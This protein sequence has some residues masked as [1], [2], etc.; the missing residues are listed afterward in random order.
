MDDPPLQE[1]RN[2]AFTIDGIA[3]TRSSNTVTDALPGTTLTLK[4]QGGAAEDLVVQTDLAAT[5]A[6]LQT[7]VDAYNGVLKLVQGEL[8]TTAQTDRG[9][10]LNGDS[11]LRYLQGRLQGL[12]A[13]DAFDDGNPLTE[14]KQLVKRLA[15]LGLKSSSKDGSLSID[16]A[17]LGAAMARD[18][19]AV[20]E[21]FARATTGIT[22]AASSLVQDFTR[23]GDGVLT[24]RKGSLDAAVKRMDDDVVRLQARL[25]KY[26]EG[27]VKRFAA[28]EDAISK[29]KS[30]GTFLTSQWNA[31]SKKE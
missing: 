21:L 12:V 2:A 25:E 13:K 17:A 18:P 8:Q 29:I 1:A 31:L 3:F 30:S 19:G 16:A 22:A 10:T 23:A 5:Q 7:F 9:R 4:A 11:S 15:D 28:M 6:R 26:R 20:N 24:S 27:L 14:E